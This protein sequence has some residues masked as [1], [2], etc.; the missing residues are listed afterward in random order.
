MKVKLSSV[1][2]LEIYVVRFVDT[3]VIK[4]TMFFGKTDINCLIILVNLFCCLT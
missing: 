1:A 2:L 4:L 3:L